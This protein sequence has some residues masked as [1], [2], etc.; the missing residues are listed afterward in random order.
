[1]FPLE[2]FN[3]TQQTFK[4]IGKLKFWKGMLFEIFQHR[5]YLKFTQIFLITTI[6]HLFNLCVLKI[7][8]KLL[9]YF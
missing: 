3:T 2:I 6:V 8:L 7:N 9:A 5:K 1:M 4:K